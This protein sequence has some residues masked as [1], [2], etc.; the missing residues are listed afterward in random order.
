MRVK[1]LIK[2][3]EQV[4]PNLYVV[5]YAN[6]HSYHSEYSKQSH[7][8]LKVGMYHRGYD[9]KE[10]IADGVVIGNVTDKLFNYPNDWMSNIIAEDSWEADKNE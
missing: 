6:N 4:D 8:P 7:S 2:A 9:E 5:T 1:E 10:N 3:L